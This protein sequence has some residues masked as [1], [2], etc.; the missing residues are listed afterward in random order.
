MTKRLYR[1]LVS[2][3]IVQRIEGGGVKRPVA[4]D[5]INVGDEA[6]AILVRR[7]YAELAGPADPVEPKGRVRRG[8]RSGAED[9]TEFGESFERVADSEGGTL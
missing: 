8:R 1:V 2:G 6:G 9:A 7:G 5:T 4:G 3:V